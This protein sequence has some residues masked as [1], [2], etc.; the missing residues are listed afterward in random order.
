LRSRGWHDA[1][2]TAIAR[3]ISQATGEV[4]DMPDAFDEAIDADLAKHEEALM[5]DLRSVVSECRERRA[6]IRKG[7]LL[8]DIKVESAKLTTGLAVQLTLCDAEMT[9]LDDPRPLLASAGPI[10]PAA[11]VDSAEQRLRAAERFRTWLSQRWDAAGGR[12][13]ADLVSIEDE[14]GILSLEE[15]GSWSFQTWDEIP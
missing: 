9:P 13:A 12:D 2:I 10:F 8:V 5:M 6:D 4:K 3:R 14:H 11:R 1:D 7:M 15:G